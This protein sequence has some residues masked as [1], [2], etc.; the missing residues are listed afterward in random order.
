MT[1]RFESKC[2][3]TGLTIKKGDKCVY[4][5]KARRAYHHD[6]RAAD[7]FRQMKFA[8]SYNMADANW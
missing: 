1:A 4:F 3:E 6:S 2:P 5:P 8:E 7:D